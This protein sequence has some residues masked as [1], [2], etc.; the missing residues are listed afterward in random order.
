MAGDRP[1]ISRNR[2]APIYKILFNQL[3]GQILI[4]V[5][6]V[7]LSSPTE[8][9]G[10]REKLHFSA[11]QTQLQI[12]ELA[13]ETNPLEFLYKLKFMPSGHDPLD[14]DRRLNLIEQL[15]QSFTYLAS[16]NAAEILFNEHPNVHRLTLNL[17]TKSGWDVETNDSGGI[18]AEV[19]AAV[20]PSNNNKLNKDIARVSTANAK[21]RYVFFMCPG[22]E[23]GL[24][25]KAGNGIIIWSLG[26]NQ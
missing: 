8:I 19:F 10:Y 23:T 17:G 16:F 2:V 5:K 1:V 18:V 11:E 26:H 14:P 6:Q 3:L 4:M 7:E 15:N 20:T 24:Y 12:A 22:Y 13:G 21:H 25:S 9:E